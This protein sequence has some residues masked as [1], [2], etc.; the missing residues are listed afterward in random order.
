MYGWSCMLDCGR[1]SRKKNATLPMWNHWFNS[2]Q[3]PIATP[4]PCPSHLPSQM[5]GVYLSNLK[6]PEGSFIPPAHTQ[7]YDAAHEASSPSLG[8]RTELSSEKFKI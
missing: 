2:R 7:M 4:E 8:L 5:N 1:H 3:Q 6:H